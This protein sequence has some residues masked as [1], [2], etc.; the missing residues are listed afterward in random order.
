MLTT[1]EDMLMSA[2]HKGCLTWFLSLGSSLK[3]GLR[4]FSTL[5][6]SN[7]CISLKWLTCKTGALFWPQFL[8]WY[9]EWPSFSGCTSQGVIFQKGKV[10]LDSFHSKWPIIHI[11]TF[12]WNAYLRGFLFNPALNRKPCVKYLDYRKIILSQQ[13]YVK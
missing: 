1:I 2:K 13:K 4:K 7:N 3:I 9:C 11:F 10:N 12:W 6:Q 8:R 5:D